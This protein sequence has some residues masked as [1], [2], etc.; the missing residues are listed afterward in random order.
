MRAWMPALHQSIDFCN[1]TDFGSKPSDQ[2][3]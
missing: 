3:R 1:K 2:W